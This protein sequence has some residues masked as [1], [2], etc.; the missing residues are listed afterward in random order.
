MTTQFYFRI[1]V[2]ICGLSF[3]YGY[4][5]RI[6]LGDDY[7]SWDL[8]ILEYSTNYN[9]FDKIVTSIYGLISFGEEGLLFRLSWGISTMIVIGLS[10]LLLGVAL[11]WVKDSADSK[12]QSS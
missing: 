10:T 11:K 2:V 1:W 3:V 6:N 12:G 9:W 8:R 4:V 5:R 7:I